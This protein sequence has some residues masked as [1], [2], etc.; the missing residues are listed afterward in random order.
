MRIAIGLL[1]ILGA[2]I[3][4][5]AFLHSGGQAL[6]AAGI[7]ENW[8]LG[9]QDAVTPVMR[10]IT[11]FHNFILIL[12]T[13]ITVFVL[14]LLLIVMIRFNAKANPTPSRTTHN[15]MIEVAWTVLPILILLVIAIPSFRLL[16][17]QRDIPP[18]DITIKAIGNQWY[19]TYEYPD[20][21]NFVFDAI[22][23]EDDELEP[24]QPRLLS[25]DNAVVV[26]VN[27]TV[28][29]VVTATDVI[30]NWAMPSFGVKMDA[31]PGRLNE[32][33]F[34][35][36]QTGVYYG[37]CSELCGIRHAFMPIT[38]NVVTEEEFASW[39]EGAQEEFAAAPTP[40]STQVADSQ[41]E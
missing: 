13:V 34:R 16:Y 14:G 27:A 31:I 21:G 37:Q 11:E 29:V 39:L 12:I 15:T 4:G 23:L 20:H 40:S 22:M 25:T 1:A 10:D 33:W 2:V 32:T 26:P 18:A 30:H 41:T 24:G 3:G 5:A 28:R 19:W 17:L 6:A 35:A 8:Q 38:V 9:F 36:E 7:S